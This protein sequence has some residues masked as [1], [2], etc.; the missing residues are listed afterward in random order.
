MAPNDAGHVD[1]RPETRPDRPR[2]PAIE[3]DPRGGHGAV[4]PDVAE[5]LLHHPRPSRL[6]GPLAQALELAPTRCSKVAPPDVG[7]EPEKFGPAPGVDRC[8]IDVDG[9]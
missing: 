7:L 6:E 5:G 1:H 9:A 3:E 8:D 4:V 2:L